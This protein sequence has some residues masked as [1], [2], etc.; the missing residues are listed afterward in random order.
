MM[1][2]IQAMFPELV[3]MAVACALLLMGAGR[4]ANVRRTSAWVALLALIFVFVYQVMATGDPQG[5]VYADDSGT[6][7]VF[8]LAQFIKL[9]SAGVGILFVL[10]AWPSNREATGNGSVDYA[11]ECGE[12]FGLMLLSI[13]GIFLVAG[14]NDIITLFLGIELASIPTYIMVSVSRPVAAAQEAGV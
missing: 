1:P 2:L 10:L 3:L 6:F 12:F 4:S 14:A 8:S 7:R 5:H 9:L 11:T 13:S